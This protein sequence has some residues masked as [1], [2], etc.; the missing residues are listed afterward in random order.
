VITH[1]VPS[2]HV[3]SERIET[4]QR[5][6]AALDAERRTRERVEM[7]QRNATQLAGAITVDEVA[8][9]LLDELSVSMGLDLTAL[10]V[11]QGDR[12]QV[13][14]PSQM[15]DE[16]VALPG[17]LDR[18]RPARPDRDP[19]QPTGGPEPDAN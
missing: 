14:A 17:R 4:E 6:E 19:D 2:G 13:I 1:L 18:C 10:N 3:I 9:A 12:L 5:L 7:L 15:P 11:L 16:A 8:S